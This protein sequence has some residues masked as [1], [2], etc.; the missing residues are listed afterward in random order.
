VPAHAQCTSPNRTH[1]PPLAFGSCAPNTP[2]SA[3]LT[4]G[5]P[6]L[7]GQATGM[8]GFVRYETILGIP[9]TPADEADIGL[10]VQISDVR[11]Q[12]T[13]ADYAGNV[14]ARA[15]ARLT[16]RNGSGADP[17]TTTNILFPLTTPC[18]PTSDPN[19]GST[20][21][22][23]TTL[24]TLIPGA[25]TEGQRTV[26]QLSQVQVIDGG[27]DGDTATDPNT[28]FLRQGVFVP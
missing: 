7:N 21:S 1:G 16:D 25:I 5:T 13:L 26:M 20:C 12:N 10:R 8:N 14:Q 24:D 18:T 22:L 11:V 27:P 19:V 4:T 3:P 17:A 9:S 23:T 28:V 6:D 15:I 2:E